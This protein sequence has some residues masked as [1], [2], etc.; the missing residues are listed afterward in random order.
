[1]LFLVSKCMF[2]L[3]N[4]GRKKVNVNTMCQDYC[5]TDCLKHYLCTRSN[6]LRENFMV[7]VARNV[8]RK[9]LYRVGYISCHYSSAFNKTI[10]K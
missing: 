4:V 10:R 1:M 9:L 3:W 7:S 8:Y 2:H 5:L 6:F